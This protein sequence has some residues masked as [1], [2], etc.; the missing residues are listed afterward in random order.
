[1]WPRHANI[2]GLQ[3]GINH[4]GRAGIS[5]CLDSQRSFWP[6]LCELESAHF[7][8]SIG[9]Q[10]KLLDCKVHKLQLGGQLVLPI[11]ASRMHIPPVDAAILHCGTKNYF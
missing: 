8:E 10:V 6:L 3:R 1:M 9:Q 7:F 5:P 11:V 4:S 2:F